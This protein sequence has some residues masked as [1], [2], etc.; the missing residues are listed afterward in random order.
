[1]IIGLKVQSQYPRINHVAHKAGTRSTSA[2]LGLLVSQPS[3]CPLQKAAATW[4]SWFVELLATPLSEATASIE[5]LSEV[6]AA[7]PLSTLAVVADVL[8]TL[9][10]PSWSPASKL[11]AWTGV[12]TPASGA[13]SPTAAAEYVD[14]GTLAAVPLLSGS[15]RAMFDSAGFTTARMASALWLCILATTAWLMPRMARSRA[16]CFKRATSSRA[17]CERST[18]ASLRAPFMVC[19]FFV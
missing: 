5:A 16:R 13:A 6:P 1:M 11:A 2:K 4:S 17:L 10:C 14:C 9:P 12:S 15:E 7:T 19:S 18:D 3:S 8:F